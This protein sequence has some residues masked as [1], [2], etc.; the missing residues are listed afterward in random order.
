M[1]Q[2]ATTFTPEVGDVAKVSQE[3][4][5]ELETIIFGNPRAIGLA[6]TARKRIALGLPRM[7]TINPGL[8]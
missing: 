4:I 8:F 1:T 5:V 2:V 3:H 7:E 6:N